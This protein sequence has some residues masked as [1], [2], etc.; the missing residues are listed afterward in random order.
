MGTRKNMVPLVID[1]FGY[2][3]LNVR[4]CLDFQGF[5]KEFYFPKGTTI[6]NAYKQIGNSVCVPVINRLAE[7]IKSVLC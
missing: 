2:R 5:P 7:Q 1:D 4:E 3:K 6:Q